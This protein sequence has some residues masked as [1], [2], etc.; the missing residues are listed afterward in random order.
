MEN[1]KN[2]KNSNKGHN[3][4][5]FFI[6]E[7]NKITGS[8]ANK[9]T[10]EKQHFEYYVNKIKQYS[11]IIEAIA[12]GNYNPKEIE[13]KYNFVVAC[14]KLYKYL[15]KIHL[16]LEKCESTSKL[17]SEFSKLI[18]PNGDQDKSLSLLKDL[19]RLKILEALGEFSN[20][21]KIMK[22]AK[23]KIEEAVKYEEIKKNEIEEEIKKEL[24]KI[25]GVSFALNK[26]TKNDYPFNTTMNEEGR[27]VCFGG[28]CTSIYK[29]LEKIYSK[30]KIN[31]EPIPEFSELT[32]PN[33]DKDKGLS[34]LKDILRLN[35]FEDLGEFPN[36]KEKM[37]NAKDK[38]EEAVNY[39]D[40][41]KCTIKFK[42]SPYDFTSDSPSLRSRFYRG[43]MLD[44]FG[45][46]NLGIATGNKSYGSIKNSDMYRDLNKINS[47]EDMVK[48]LPDSWKENGNPNDE[49]EEDAQVVITKLASFVYEQL[50]EKKD[51]GKEIGLDISKPKAFRDSKKFKLVS[52]LVKYLLEK[53]GYDKDEAVL[54]GAGR[55]GI[56]VQTK[57]ANS[58]EKVYLK[59]TDLDEEVD[60][61]VFERDSDVKDYEETDDK[62]K[63]LSQV[64]NMAMYKKI[65][66]SFNDQT[67]ERKAK[68]AITE[69]EYHQPKKDIKASD[70]L[71]AAID[72][73]VFFTW[74]HS[75]KFVHCD[76]KRDNII[77][78]DNGTKVIDIDGIQ[79]EG[80]GRPQSTRKNS[81]GRRIIS[82]FGKVWVEQT[83]DLNS[84]GNLMNEMIKSYRSDHKE[85]NESDTG[86]LNGLGKIATRCTKYRHGDGGYDDKRKVLAYDVLEE[87]KELGNE[88]GLKGEL[89]KHLKQA[90]PIKNEIINEAKKQIEEIKEER[91]IGSAKKCIK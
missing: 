5:F 9:I 68:A 90:K 84:F 32:N 19:L 57:R 80:Y 77:I 42:I 39:I 79:E 51:I 14:K 91:E 6:S 10:D 89:E 88:Q 62:R 7:T 69:V 56:F 55:H 26:V 24:E 2:S 35:I 75:H 66:K 8:E 11:I 36:F 47:V 67:G 34:L 60:I 21:K 78:T 27:E 58:Q 61:S 53:Y 48:A 15:K 31:D 28:V 70:L 76:I 22:D 29:C 50:K 18:D 73:C 59:F 4:K 85:I 37:K 33:K 23:D 71:F 87:L 45:L 83:D 54:L 17:T 46:T 49:F 13:K 3:R 30:T 38:I 74:L 1:S 86:I 40:G 82:L 25:E 20:L 81:L 44:L 52:L 64:K 16:H 72:I 12:K 41:G 65:H 43:G 63:K